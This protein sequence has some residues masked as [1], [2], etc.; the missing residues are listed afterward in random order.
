[1][2][3]LWLFDVDVLG[4]KAVDVIE[5]EARIIFLTAWTPSEPRTT[6]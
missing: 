2:S 4:A 1:L 6:V 3:D 5:I